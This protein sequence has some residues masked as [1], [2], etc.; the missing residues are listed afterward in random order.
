M[1]FINT[2]R[3]RRGVKRMPRIYNIL[4]T[5]CPAYIIMRLKGAREPVLS[6]EHLPEDR[7]QD[8]E[9]SPWAMLSLALLIF[10]TQVILLLDLLILP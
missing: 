5:R 4:N 6:L 1:L 9:C 8:G 10:S 3:L 2:F 7:V